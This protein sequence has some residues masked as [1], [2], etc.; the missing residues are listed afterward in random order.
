MLFVLSVPFKWFLSRFGFM[1][2]GR[3]V[4]TCLV[5]R[6]GRDYEHSHSNP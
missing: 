1:A 6:W 5:T 3:E 4:I 2:P